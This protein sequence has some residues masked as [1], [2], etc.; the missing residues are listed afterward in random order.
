MAVKIG[1]A[2]RDE[3]LKASGGKAGDQ[4]GKE[5]CIRD[6]YAGNW[7][8]LLRPR[9]AAVAEKMA[10]FCEDVCNNPC[11]GY[12]QGQRNSLRTAALRADWNGRKILTDCETDCSAFMTVCAEAAGVDMQRFYY[13]GNAPTTWTMRG[14]FAAT[15]DFDVL[16]D[17]KY[18]VRSDYLKRGDILVR[19]S[20][21]TCMV[22]S[23][24]AKAVSNASNTEDNA[25]NVLNDALANAQ[26][27]V[28]K[29]V[30]TVQAGDTLWGISRKYGTTVNALCAENGISAKGFIYPGQKIT[31]P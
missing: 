21:H 29:R 25:L 2:S 16:T 13:F 19:E 4:D 17:S 7:N 3:R 22:L 27:R 28:K 1:H 11:V 30:H 31:I 8:V 26:E 23:D 15:G 20:G 5:V 14:T 24:G 9:S 10:R 12:D 18:L 6:W